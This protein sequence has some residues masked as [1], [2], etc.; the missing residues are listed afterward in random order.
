MGYTKEIWNNLSGNEKQPASISKAWLELP[1][2]QRFALS[3]LGY[4]R[5]S[6]DGRQPDVITKVFCIRQQS[7]G[8]LW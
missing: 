7:D 1:D 8:F 2:N 6:W 5:D 3:I 4:T